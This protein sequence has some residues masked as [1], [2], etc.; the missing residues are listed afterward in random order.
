MTRKPAEIATDQNNQAG[1][2]TSEPFWARAAAFDRHQQGDQKAAVEN[3]D[4]R[5][6]EHRHLIG[7][8]HDAIGEAPD[9]IEHPHGDQAPQQEREPPSERIAD[10]NKPV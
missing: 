10:G 9:L 7:R 4:D 8:E 3:G 6:A 1:H 2:L 5:R